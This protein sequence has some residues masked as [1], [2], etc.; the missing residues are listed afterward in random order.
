RDALRRLA[1]RARRL[2]ARRRRQGRRSLPA[3]HARRRR[4]RGRAGAR[5]RRL[6]GE[7]PGPRAR[8]VRR[9][10]HA[11]AGLLG[12]PRAQV[13]DR[14]PLGA[15]A[16]AFA[17]CATT[18]AAPPA[19]RWEADLAA[20]RAHRARLAADVRQVPD[21]FQPPGADPIERP[22]PAPFACARYPVGRI[23]FLSCRGPLTP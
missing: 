6:R 18:P 2:Q 17:A 4:A 21:A 9:P 5:R 19:L 8:A 23:E 13:S 15:L 3:P 11:R 14:R 22:A 1:H 16:L 12:A 10:A 7:A 20:Y